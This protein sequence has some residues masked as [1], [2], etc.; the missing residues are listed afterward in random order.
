MS[1]VLSACCVFLWL[2]RAPV[3]LSLGLVWLQV[4]ALELWPTGLSRVYRSVITELK[5]QADKAS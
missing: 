1:A 3:S 4:R 2:C 5:W